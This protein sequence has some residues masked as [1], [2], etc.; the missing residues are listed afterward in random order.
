MVR[1]CR[2]NQKHAI[3]RTYVIDSELTKSFNIQLDGS[4][5]FDGQRRPGCRDQMTTRPPQDGT[6]RDPENHGDEDVRG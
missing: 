2:G 5:E 1:A 3:H 4:N 6:S